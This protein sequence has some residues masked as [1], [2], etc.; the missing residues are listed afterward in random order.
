MGKEKGE[1][2]VAEPIG[3]ERRKEEGRERKHRE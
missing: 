2:E 1:R 3:R